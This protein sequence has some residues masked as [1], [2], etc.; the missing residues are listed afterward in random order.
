VRDA[1]QTLCDGVMCFEEVCCKTEVWAPE[2][3]AKCYHSV[4]RN[5]D[6]LRVGTATHPEHFRFSTVY[7]DSKRDLYT[8]TAFLHF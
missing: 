5:C 4:V 2:L 8:L 6:K 7:I 3:Q 1:W